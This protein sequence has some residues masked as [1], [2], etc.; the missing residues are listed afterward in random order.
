MKLS[1]KRNSEI[2]KV[3]PTDAISSVGNAKLEASRSSSRLDISADYSQN[4]NFSAPNSSG[5]RDESSKLK[6]IPVAPVISKI[7][8]KIKLTWADR[9]FRNF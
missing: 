7:L 3:S 2:A 4:L 1:D 9:R 5:G 8:T 6:I